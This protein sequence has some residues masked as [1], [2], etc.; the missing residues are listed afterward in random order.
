MSTQEIDRGRAGVDVDPSLLSPPMVMPLYQCATAVVV[1]GGVAGAEIEV[2]VNGASVATGVVS[3]V[4]PYGITIAVPAPLVANDQVRAR[5]RTAT[6]VSDSSAPV[7][8]GDHTVDYPAGPPRPEVFTL[9]LY[10]CGVR[11]GV[12][13]LL[14]GGNVWVTAD[15]V[16]VGRVKGCGTPQGVNVNPAFGLAQ[17]VRAWFELCGDPSPPSIEH[18]GDCHVQR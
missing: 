14:V 4:L 17:K 2:E 10:E 18:K 16:E 5:Q 13:N 3:T 6:A 1:V 7:T 11:T 9:P 12:A 8:V 15:G